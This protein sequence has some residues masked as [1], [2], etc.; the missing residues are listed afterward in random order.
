[1]CVCLLYL[2]LGL[3]KKPESVESTSEDEDEVEKQKVKW[4][5]MLITDVALPEFCKYVFVS[6]TTKFHRTAIEEN[7]MI[8]IV[9]AFGTKITEKNGRWSML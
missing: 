9:K 6:R 3:K 4:F 2:H 5:K 7:C 8:L 1:M